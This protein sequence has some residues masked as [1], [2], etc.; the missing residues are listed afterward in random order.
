MPT[1][2]ATANHPDNLYD[3]LIH[4]PDTGWRQF[5]ILDADS[6]VATISRSTARVVALRGG[7]VVWYNDT[8]D[9]RP[10]AT[11]LGRID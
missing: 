9:V 6:A 7:R 4:Y 2:R 1:P 11:Y 5:A 8:R 3:L 10:G